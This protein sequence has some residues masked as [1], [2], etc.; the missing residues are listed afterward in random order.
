MQTLAALADPTR[1]RIVELL[2]E[3]DRSAGELV[4]KFQMSASAISQHLKV[5]HE[6]KLVSVRVEGQRRIQM[7]NLRGIDEIG[8]WVARTRQVWEKRL[9]AL[10]RVLREEDAKARVSKSA[11]SAKSAK[12]SKSNKL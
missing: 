2:A 6:A 7:L 3:C 10:E 5:L 9:D 1:R 8:A 11:K 12:S 4:A